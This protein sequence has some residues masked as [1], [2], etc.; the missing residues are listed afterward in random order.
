MKKLTILIVIITLL[1]FQF[2]AQNNDK[3]ALGDLF[4]DLR[5]RH[6]GP[7]LMSGRINDLE[8]HPT[9]PRI[10]YAG[11]A[12]GGVWKSNDA[13][14]TFNPIFD[15]YCQSIGA[16]EID[17]NDPDHV[18]YV[19]TGE[20]WTRNSVSYGD[21]LYKSTDGGT[22]W[23]KLGFD[24]S[25][26]IANIIVNPKNSNEIYVAVLGA[27][28]S[29]SDERG[30]YKSMDAGETWEN[31]LYINERTGAA[32]MT[33]DPN[34]PSTLYASMWE[35][36]RTGWS[37]ESGGENSALYKSIDA[38]KTWNKIHNGFPEG[39]LG[40]LAIAVA[41]SNSNILYTVI[42]AE[43]AERKGL[44]R[45]DDAGNSW[46]QLNND[47]GIT[48]RPFYFSRITIDP[49]NP[50]VIVKGGLNGSIS[51]DGGKTFKSLGNMH[52][53][54]H[55]IVFDIND[56][57]RIYAG[58][59]GGVY[60][61]WNGG[62]T[63]EI[64]ENLP[65]S[66][67]YHIS[68]DN[69]EP[70]NVY[71]GLQDNGSWYGPSSS[72]GGVNA[73]DWKSIGAGDGFRVL[74][75]PTKNIIYSEMQGAENVWRYDVD[76]KLVKTIQPLAQEGHEE[77]RFNWNAPM[78]VSIHQPDRFYMGS[79]FLHKSEDMGDTWEII[80]PDLTTNDP[81][82]QNQADSGGLSMDNSGAENHTTIFTIAESPLDENII[83]VGTD[84]GNV[85]VTKDGGKTWSNTVGNIQGLPKHTWTY[86]IEASVH[87]KGTAYAVFDGHTTGDM[88]PYTFKTTDFGKTWTNIISDDVVGTTR[89]IQEDYENENL[90][91][92]GTE[93][94]L[95]IT[96]DGGKSWSKFTKNMP[97][98]AVHFIDLQKR[99]NDLVMGTHGRGVIIIDD[100]SPLR[101]ITPEVLAE[102]LYFFD[103]EPAVFSDEGGFSGSFGIETQFVGQ[104]ASTLP[105]I[106]YL[107]PKRHT[108]GKMIMEIKDMEG[109]VISTLTPGKSKGINIVNWNGKIK[110]PKIAKG[111]TFS[112]GGFTSP[113][114]PAG[115]YKAVITKGKELF[116]HD[117][118]VVHDMR[119]G[120]SEVDLKFKHD[121]TMK[122]YNMTQELA[123][124]VYKLDAILESPSTQ[125][126]LKSSLNALK[127]TLVVTTGDNYVG[128]AKPQLREKMANLYSKVAS[129]Y[130]KPSNNELE[131]LKIIESQFNKAKTSFEKLENKAKNVKFKSFQ[132]FLEE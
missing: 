67:F 72:I 112:F 49:R 71:G 12:G 17:P 9:D 118:E 102:K 54:I 53:D 129:S 131:N 104:N 80:S 128:S 8:A 30:V 79:Q 64:V 90:L 111:K 114:V 39:Q 73:A 63:M 83:W 58:T 11:T 130:D 1:P 95:Y 125:G 113:R 98:V 62:T 84:D 25:E 108:F 121:L 76:R 46:K 124:L 57:D 45:S 44:Y 16:V 115:Q 59:D 22:T 52:S 127:E 107:L 109:N 65:L 61:S 37:F 7:A 38:G 93:F 89:N 69:E 31:I 123:Y 116:E 91:F 48:V 66:Q 18:I 97:S 100:I 110:N 36:R 6:I 28:W 27:L 56:S 40:R 81:N 85:Q 60:R 5:A 87:G 119:T 2:Q 101:N 126:K 20:T 43:Q 70:Y 29:D 14:T 55:D 117:F 34:N 13:G 26:R 10:I 68:V 21:G 94:G 120:L 74:K 105:Q 24:K 92:L 99:T 33:M 35:F 23:K 78:A 50:D 19:G 122:L 4:G 41:P 51:R 86:H 77:L 75:H 42:E 106:K 47:F 132:E 15:D 32:D 3:I 88:K 82:K 103:S 96:I